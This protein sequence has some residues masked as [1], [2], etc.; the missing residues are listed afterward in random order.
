M[1]RKKRTQ[2]QASTIHHSQVWGVGVSVVCVLF[3]FLFNKMVLKPSKNT[4]NSKAKERRKLFQ[5]SQ[6]FW[7][8]VISLQPT[9]QLAVQASLSIGFSGCLPSGAPLASSCG[10]V[11]IGP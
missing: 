4:A 11:R 8:L 5:I 1:G 9:K 2:F 7:L 3:R 6:L 10:C